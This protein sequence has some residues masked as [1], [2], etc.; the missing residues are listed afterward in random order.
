MRKIAVLLIIFFISCNSK[1]KKIEEIKE[2]KTLSKISVKGN[3]FVTQSGN[4][5]VFR[6]L[7]T[8]DPD[9]LEKDGHWDLEYFQEIKKWGATLVRFPV[10]PKAWRER[11][12]N[13]YLKL[14]DKGIQWA[15]DLGL[16][17]IIDWHSIGNLK[18]E[19]FY[20]DI[21]ETS[22]EETKH[23]WKTMSNK[24]KDNSTVA[25]FEIFNE[26]TTNGGTLGKVTW[27]E[28][29]EINENLIAI[30]RENGCKTI[31]LVAGFNWGYNLKPINKKPINAKE[32]GYVSH[33]YPQKREHPWNDKWTEDW[34]FAAEK[35]PIILTEIGFCEPDDEGAHVPVIG[36]ES[37]GDAIKEYSDDRGISYMIWVFDPN[38]SPRLFNNWNFEPSKH[39]KYFKNA[40][41]SY[42]KKE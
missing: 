19:K 5:I 1:E 17:I 37:Y 3:S 20:L 41:Q 12:E 21:Y 23:F 24:Y 8:S 9:K 14:L 4:P 15:T 30:I 25:F 16:Y 40:M 39:G 22:M 13:E 42:H 2:V 29:K 38:W 35:Y 34:G 6:G 36:D 33:P 31:P 7:N 10:H 18:E 32:I 26:P 11:G 28:W 27:D